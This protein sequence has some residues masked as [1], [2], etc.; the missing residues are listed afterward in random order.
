MNI[1]EQLTIVAKDL[2]SKLS[3]ITNSPI[4]FRVGERN[5]IILSSETSDLILEL[6]NS[7]V[8]TPE[9]REFRLT[10]LSGLSSIEPLLI[11]VYLPTGEAFYPN[12]TEL[13]SDFSSYLKSND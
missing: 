1:R 5:E 8:R 4:N 13:I 6:K 2:C 9:I 7:F 10:S 12:G 3:L 11:E